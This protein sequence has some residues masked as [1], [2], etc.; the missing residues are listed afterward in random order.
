MTHR[1]VCF[2]SVTESSPHVSPQLRESMDLYEDIVT[3]EQQ[4]R[5]SLYTEVRCCTFRFFFI[6]F[7]HFPRFA[8][9]QLCWSWV[10]G[11]RYLSGISRI[12]TIASN[13]EK[14]T[15]N[16][17]NLADRLFLWVAA[18]FVCKWSQLSSYSTATKT[19]NFESSFFLGWAELFLIE[20]G[21]K[22]GWDF[23]VL[24]FVFLSFFLCE[25]VDTVQFCMNAEI[26][27]HW[28]WRTLLRNLCWRHGIDFGINVEKTL[29]IPSPDLCCN[30]AS[31]AHSFIHSFIAKGWFRH[32]WNRC[33]KSSRLNGLISLLKRFQSEIM[34]FIKWPQA[35]SWM[36]WVNW[37]NWLVHT[38]Y[39]THCHFLFLRYRFCSKVNFKGE[40]TEDHTVL[41][42]YKIFLNQARLFVRTT[43]IWNKSS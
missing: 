40:Y 33:D 25:T 27:I 35:F 1:A 13:M 15:F 43:L 17:V 4:S 32:Q 5:A 34:R 10:I 38:Y 31:H 26:L 28:Y 11:N 37:L 19:L 9:A 39:T 14:R 23:K 20:L 22:L 12:A 36:Q 41:H 21:E 30:N 6:Y 18:V 29:T 3:E 7:L 16:P 42:F 2:S 24:F 8:S